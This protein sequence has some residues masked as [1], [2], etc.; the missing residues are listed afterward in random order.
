M[1]AP[2]SKTQILGISPN[3]CEIYAQ[4]S[5]VQHGSTLFAFPSEY[6]IFIYDRQNFKQSIIMTPDPSSQIIALTFTGY[7]EKCHLLCVNSNST[8]FSYSLT[9]LFHPTQT[10]QLNYT[11]VSMTASN[12]L[13]FYQTQNSIFAVSLISAHTHHQPIILTETNTHKHCLVSPCGRALATFT[14]GGFHPVI[15]YAPFKKKRCAVLPLQ[16]RVADF[17][18]GI[19][20]H[21]IAVTANQDGVL[22]LWIESTTSYELRCVKWFQFD[23]QI[24]STAICISTDIENQI[25]KCP[26]TASHSGLMFPLVR[27]PPV[28]I[29]AVLNCP[30]KNVCILQETANPRLEKVTRVSLSL[31]NAV[32]TISDMKRIFSNHQIKRLISFMR[33]SSNSLS[34]FQLELG[35]NSIT[36][37]TPFS[38]E[39][40]KSPIVKILKN[41]NA[42]TIHKDKSVY[43]WQNSKSIEDNFTSIEM[44]TFLGG[45]L[46]VTKSSIDY[47]H[48]KQTE[49][50]FSYKLNEPAEFASI[51]LYH[52]NPNN[53]IHNNSNITNNI[54]N[55]NNNTDHTTYNINN[56]MSINDAKCDDLN[57]IAM[58]VVC[59]F[60]SVNVFFF[61]GEKITE[62]PV[63]LCS[64]SIR[65]TT[66]HS[67]NL[68][69][70]STNKSVDAYIFNI[71]HF[72]KFA[73][74]SA[75]KPS[76]LFLPHPMA[77]IAIS[78]RK[79]LQFFIVW[80]TC[81]I[82]I[83]EFND[84]L[85]DEK[86]IPKV[87]TMT[88]TEDNLL[89]AA[90]K[91]LFI[92]FNFPDDIFPIPPNHN[93]IYILN[94]SLSLSSFYPLFERING[95]LLNDSSFAIKMNSESFIFPSE[96]PNDIPS[97]ISHICKNPPP[98]W[99]TLDEN[100]LKFLFSWHVSQGNPELWKFI[101]LF[102]I[103]ALL[104]GDQ[105]SLIS[106]LSIKTAKSLI[107]L[108]LPIWAKNVNII[109][110]A[111]TLL[112]DESLPN[113][114]EV[115]TYLLFCVALN[116]LNTARKI[117]RVK[118]Q[119]KLA[120]FFSSINSDDPKLKIRIE[121]SAYEA[122]K[123]HRSSLSAMFFIL[124]GM[125][126]QALIVL[127]DDKILSL[128]IARLLNH[129]DWYTNIPQN[130]LNGFYQKYWETK[131]EHIN[132]TVPVQNN[133]EVF[134][135]AIYALKNW[136]YERTN[137]LS[138]E[139]HIFKIMKTF[140]ALKPNDLLSLQF[141]PGFLKV[142]SEEKEIEIV[143]FLDNIITTN[144]ETENYLLMSAQSMENMKKFAASDDDSEEDKNKKKN[145]MSHGFD[146][147]YGI[148]DDFDEDFDDDY[149]EEDSPHEN[150]RQN[151]PKEEKIGNGVDQ[152]D[153]NSV[154]IESKNET[155]TKK[156][157]MFESDFGERFLLPKYHSSPPTIL[158]FSENYVVYLISCIINGTYNDDTIKFSA[159]VADFL[160]DRPDY[161]PIVAGILYAITLAMSRPNLMIL[162]FSWPFNIDSLRYLLYDLKNGTLTISND[163]K[164]NI[165]K[166]ITPSDLMIT[167]SDR[168]LANF[169][170]LNEI[171]LVLSKLA[172]NAGKRQFYGILSYF[173][174]LFRL[175]FDLL[176]SPF[177]SNNN[178]HQDLVTL[179]MHC[180]DLPELMHNSQI[181]KK[182][183]IS[184]V[185]PFIS[186]FYFAD[187][188]S[189]TRSYEVP[190]KLG[191]NS[192]ALGICVNNVDQQLA[193]V[194]SGDSV[195]VIDIRYSAGAKN[196]ISASDLSRSS[197][198]S[199]NNIN[200][201]V[202]ADSSREFSLFDSPLAN[203]TIK[204]RHAKAVNRFMMFSK[205]DFSPT[206][207]KDR[208]LLSNISG[209]CVASHPYEPFFL[210]GTKTGRIYLSS[211]DSPHYYGAAT[212]NSVMYNDSAVTSIAM[213]N[214]GDKILTTNENGFIFLSDFQ[215]AN[216]FVSMPGAS[217]AWL[218]DDTQIIVCEPSSNSLFV[219]D[220]IA[221]THP[222]ATFSLNKKSKKRCPIDVF[223]S[224]VITGYDDGSVV[225]LDLKSGSLQ[226]MYI[227]ES[228][229]SA[230]K[231]D[232]SGRFFVSA[233]ADNRL[234]IVNAKV[235]SVP[236]DLNGVFS[237]YIMSEEGKRGVTDIELTNHTIVACGYSS[238][239]HVWRVSDPFS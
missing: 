206:W 203:G 136:K 84:S 106:S 218:N 220:V 36:K 216:L 213:N 42:H 38:L 44:T 27:R 81:F 184:L 15:Y 83:C 90:T 189:S 140:G 107:D 34:F 25:T 70:V 155:I 137:V 33:F 188:F 145:D 182:W 210:S 28:L 56:S 16:G 158:T 101:P 129:E 49:L 8:F 139:L 225:M 79:S 21:L 157:K 65:S 237:D 67:T 6:L 10:I 200:N 215:T 226:T 177:F 231:F 135:D 30:K 214:T 143:D 78:F 5:L 7:G 43:D 165:L 102:G 222:V 122:Q 53:H 205:R 138:I 51:Y 194:C 195:E 126:K 204:S 179:G 108:M 104:S 93:S 118:N 190:T 196:S 172:K 160:F 150:N 199:N 60:H 32:V 97:T 39:F 171:C 18:W 201:S 12:N 125:P 219:Y 152:N 169:F 174:H 166:H 117:A 110:K 186:P 163:E 130:L 180:H 86:I 72:S 146:F 37:T 147:S 193:A 133:V 31:E 208:T 109:I 142:E 88:I 170:S 1:F 59:N 239:A 181:D 52:K 80:N 46:S 167:E 19:S 141:T 178:F 105:S 82:P 69:A 58:I 173:H 124:R 85:S 87:R 23:Y 221:G 217:A 2:L 149:E 47:F 121:K 115:D 235:E 54:D 20:E 4:T 151:E 230:I 48:Q 228:P 114:N 233:A 119:T 202:S 29:L 229:V 131:M 127:R 89:L 26:R 176:P 95:R 45:K 14:R 96:T 159:Q 41:K 154:G 116:K 92:E 71:D 207:T 50:N 98:N 13:L 232:A 22:R 91:N 113:D 227:H 187:K 197:S 11:P 66:I 212:S 63:N 9:D 168:L 211:F 224:Q 100:G 164:P 148:N 35:E 24:L 191:S 55:F 123:Q 183:K 40:M 73:S 61:D 236:Q 223:G 75:E 156:E 103:W 175:N 161:S 17:Q 94:T 209:L 185:N 62:I 111:V 128:I 162:L 120:A 68:F 112:I 144:E 132:D 99:G 64:N 134:G 57:N 3:N 77:L 198:I 192:T 234:Q 74:L 153:N 238:F 76:A